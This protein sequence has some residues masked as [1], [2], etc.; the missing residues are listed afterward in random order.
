MSSNRQPSRRLPRA[1]FWGQLGQ[2]TQYLKGR[3]S[4]R[5]SHLLSNPYARFESAEDIAI[6]VQVGI[7]IDANRATVDDWLRLPGLSIHQARSLVS[8]NHSGIQFYCL[9]DL[10]AAVSLPLQ[11]LRVWEPILRFYHYEPHSVIRP[12]RLDPNRAT[13][14]QLSQVP[15]IDLF[16]ARQIVRQRQSLGRYQSFT[17]FY[18]QL[19]LPPTLASELMHYLTF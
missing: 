12:Q 16:L 5:R 17:H 4:R 8:L 15:G 2:W 10:A 18:Q 13:V 7:S 6:A 11:T 9:E 3:V 1:R 19:G 14:E